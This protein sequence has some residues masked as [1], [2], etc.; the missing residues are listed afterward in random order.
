MLNLTPEI[1][2]LSSTIPVGRFPFSWQISE[3]RFV[4]FGI[5][6]AAEIWQTFQQKPL[7]IVVNP[8]YLEGRPGGI[9]KL[10]REFIE[11]DYLRVAIMDEALRKRVL[12]FSRR[13]DRQ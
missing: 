8:E 12:I 10:F 2:F 6:A 4:P 13:A 5:D 11:R 3:E 1:D 7:L 9:A